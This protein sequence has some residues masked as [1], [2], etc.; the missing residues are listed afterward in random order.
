MVKG[1]DDICNQVIKKVA[2]VQPDWKINIKVDNDRFKYMQQA[3]QQTRQNPYQ[4]PGQHQR[5][6]FDQKQQQPY[7]SQQNPG[8]SQPPQQQTYQ[9]PGQQMVP[10]PT[11]PFYSHH[12]QYQQNVSEP[13]KIVGE[14]HQRILVREI[15]LGGIPEMC[16]KH[17]MHQ[18]MSE[19]GMV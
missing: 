9:A 3:Q 13:E 12:N 4:Q 15:W 17:Y 18:L 19:F 7:Y 1:N 16:D 8:Q 6:N 2:E 10:P 14:K 5:M 11:Q